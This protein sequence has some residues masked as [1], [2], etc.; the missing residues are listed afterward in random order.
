MD[1]CKRD[2]APPGGP[3]VRSRSG[4]AVHFAWADGVFRVALVVAATGCASPACRRASGPVCGCARVPQCSPFC[5]GRWLRIRGWVC[6]THGRQF[7]FQTGRLALRGPRVITRSHPRRGGTRARRGRRCSDSLGWTEGNRREQSRRNIAEIK[8]GIP[9]M[10]RIAASATA[11]EAGFAR[12]TETVCVP[13]WT[14]GLP[15]GSVWGVRVAGPSGHHPQPPE[16]RRHAG[17]SRPSLLR[18][19][20]VDRGE[21]T[22]TEPEEYC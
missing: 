12:H 3:A 19:A 22:G 2:P 21:Q 7:A 6:S 20:W 15:P 13:D 16:A 9:A 5:I 1:E 14:G 17:S 10:R 8:M 11:S 4:R 18:L